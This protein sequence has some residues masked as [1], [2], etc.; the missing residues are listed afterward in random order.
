MTKGN[1]TKRK[2]KWITPEIQDLIRLRR[3]AERKL[4]NHKS[5]EN[6]KEYR[7]LKGLTKLMLKRKRK[8]E[9]AKYVNS[10]N[11]NTPSSQIWA[12]SDDY[13]GKRL[14]TKSPD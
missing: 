14:C 11:H 4:K 12:R 5:E 7:R 8:E 9:W 13:Q 1:T 2:L 3:R 10:I 6:I